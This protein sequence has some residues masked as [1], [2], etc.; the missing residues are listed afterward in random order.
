MECKTI[1]VLS[2]WSRKPVLERPELRGLWSKMWLSVIKRQMELR[3]SQRMDKC[4][5]KRQY[6]FQHGEVALTEGQ[7]DIFYLML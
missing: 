3:L 1:D 7:V 5:L 2:E 4:I 6:L